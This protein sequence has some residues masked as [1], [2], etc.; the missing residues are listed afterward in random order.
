MKK[1]TAL[2][3]LLFFVT[4]LWSQESTNDSLLKILVQDQKTMEPLPYANILFLQQQKGTISNES[5]WFAISLAELNKGDTLSVQYLGYKTKKISILELKS[6]KMIDLEED[7]INLS[8][9]WVYG[10]PPKAKDIIRKVIENSEKNYTSI[11]AKRQVFIRNRQNTDFKDFSSDIKRNSI[12]EIDQ[13]QIDR[14]LHKI[15]KHI[16]SFT[17]FLG[18]TYSHQNS[19]DSLK[20][21]SQKI[22]S[23]K[24]IEIDELDQFGKIF[25]AMFKETDEEEYWKVKSGIFGEK[26]DMEE[27]TSSDS[28]EHKI[29]EVNHDNQMNKGGIKWNL[30]SQLQYASLKDE[31]QWEF[32]YKTGKYKYELVGGTKVNGEDVFIIDFKP[33]GGGKFVGR[34]YV[35][36]ST[37]AL[38]K[39]DYKYADGKDGRDIQ[40]LGI[41]YHENKYRTSI[42]YEKIGESYQLKYLSHSQAIGMSFNRKVALIK[43]KKRW[44][45]DKTL[46]ELKV[47]LNIDVE[48]EEIT[49]LLFLSNDAIPSED[50]V[51]FEEPEWMDVIYVDHFSDDLWKGYPIIEP[52]KKMREYQKQEVN[53]SELGGE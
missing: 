51:K 40:L 13:Q 35:S 49:E 33:S 1:L 29:D 21:S 30:K 46:L 50:F 39:A 7:L 53:W 43:K 5:G 9:A 16:S 27:E 32:L 11:S 12:S 38:I 17:D 47:K 31:K 22:V 34:V 23:L 25:E 2:L 41:G 8:E 15:P 18:H 28:T 37:Y 24:D 52:T 42:Y 45:I 48:T 36:T 4:Q 14:I 44:L 6:L 3:V 19:L 26:I 20:I 10:N